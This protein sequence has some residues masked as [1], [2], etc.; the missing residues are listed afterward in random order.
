MTLTKSPGASSRPPA[1]L[2]ARS[3][4]SR[5]ESFRAVRSIGNVDSC[6]KM[7]RMSRPA[8]KECQHPLG[9]LFAD[10]FTLAQFVAQLFRETYGTSP[11]PAIFEAH[12]AANFEAEIFSN[13]TDTTAILHVCAV[14]PP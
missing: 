6:L 9:G 13:V 8:R 11:R 14:T 5:A 7:N 3:S 10:A 4:L 1:L 12:V 2:Y